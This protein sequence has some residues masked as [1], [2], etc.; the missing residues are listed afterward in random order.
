MK[1]TT[2][3]ILLIIP[4]F[5]LLIAITNAAQLSD[6][7]TFD[8]KYIQAAPTKKIKTQI[9]NQTSKIETAIPGTVVHSEGT[10]AKIKEPDGTIVWD[11]PTGTPSRLWLILAPNPSRPTEIRVELEMLAQDPKTTKPKTGDSTGWPYGLSL[12]LLQGDTVTQIGESK[13]PAALLALKNNWRK[14]DTIVPI[15]DNFP[16][17]LQ[18]STNGVGGVFELKSIKIT[19]KT[20]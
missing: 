8:T 14:I 19:E 7:V 1:Q 11:N 17:I 2:K 20:P 12:G 5:S 3:S 4:L 15:S 9:K 16:V 10:T 18:I 6:L 13:P